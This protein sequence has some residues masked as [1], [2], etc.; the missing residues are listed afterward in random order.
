VH[1]HLFGCADCLR[2][3]GQVRVTSR[4]LAR[5]PTRELTDELNAELTNVLRA[6]P[7]RHSP[8]DGTAGC[9]GPVG[10]PAQRGECRMGSRRSR[11]V[12]S[13]TS[14][15]PISSICAFSS[16]GGSLRSPSRAAASEVK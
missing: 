7:D 13:P 16:A 5:L 8:A 4:L 12:G 1:E 11:N 15:L 10:D 3:L 2:Y 6:A 14:S 9:R